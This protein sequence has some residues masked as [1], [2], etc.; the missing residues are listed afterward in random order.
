MHIYFH[1]LYL[2]AAL[3]SDATEY[4]CTRGNRDELLEFE[5]QKETIWHWISKRCVLLTSIPGSLHVHHIPQR[6]EQ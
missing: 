5:V 3:T 4:P 1:I 6:S 2:N